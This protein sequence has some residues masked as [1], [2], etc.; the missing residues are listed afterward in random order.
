MTYQ[1]KKNRITILE[2]LR[3]QWICLGVAA[4]PFVWYSVLKNHSYDHSS[5]TYR[6]MV[7]AV[8]GVWFAILNTCKERNND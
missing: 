3:K 1:M 7:V 5:F 6:A 4:F 8:L 2:V